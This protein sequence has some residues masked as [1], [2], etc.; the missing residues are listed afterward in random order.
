MWRE[1]HVEAFFKQEGGEVRPGVAELAVRT[2]QALE[3][4][5][6]RPSGMGALVGQLAEGVV[7]S[8]P[9]LYGL[10]KLGKALEQQEKELELQLSAA[11]AAAARDT[12]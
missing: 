8:S 5:R 2:Q 10:Y 12:A 1:S 11:S 4:E 3:A 7:P 9:R 6:I